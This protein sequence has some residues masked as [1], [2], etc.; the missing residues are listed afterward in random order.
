[1]APVLLEFARTTPDVRS[2]L[3]AM[4]ILPTIAGDAQFESLLTVVQFSPNAELRTAAEDTAAAVLKK[5]NK[6]GDLAK[7]ITKS[8]EA[9][10]DKK[11]REPLLRLQIAGR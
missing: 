2:A 4:Q 7:L 9:T 8:L 1:M 6:R 5:S 11:A 3:A 10:S